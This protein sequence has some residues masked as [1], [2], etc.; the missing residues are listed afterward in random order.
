MPSF[1]ERHGFLRSKSIRYREE[2][3]SNLRGPIIDLAVGRIG[4]AALLQIVTNVLDPYG[5]EPPLLLISSPPISQSP[6]SMSQ[7]PRRLMRV[8]GDATLDSVREAIDE[9]H[10]YRVYDV[11][12]SIY[13]FLT[14]PVQDQQGQIIKGREP[15]F[16]REINDYF[17]YA[18]IG[19]QL[20]N[21]VIKTRGDETFESTVNTAVSVL[22]EDQKPTAARHLQFAISARRRRSR[23]RLFC[24][25]KTKRSSSGSG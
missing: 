17:A 2:L 7:P 6:F 22:E 20:R 16:E 25:W 24:W 19:W 4:S 8:S 13:Q 15:H 5:I 11:V 3:P 12:E 9:C 1:S 18:E 14:I 23:D 10:W 21:G